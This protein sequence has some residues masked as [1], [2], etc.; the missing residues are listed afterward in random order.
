MDSRRLMPWCPARPT[1]CS[2]D[3]RVVLRRWA[4]A[5]MWGD[6]RRE[7]KVASRRDANIG[8]V[9]NPQTALRL[10][11]AIEIMPLRGIIGLVVKC[12]TALRLSGVIKIM[13]LQGIVVGQAEGIAV[14]GADKLE[15][16]DWG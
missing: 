15:V 6:N 16:A 7:L 3:T 9:A 11:G 8:L 13:P 10:S 1:G 14:V 12:Q 2:S 4:H 5:D